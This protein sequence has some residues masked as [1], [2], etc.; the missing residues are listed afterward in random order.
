MRNGLWMTGSGGSGI[1]IARKS[2]GTWSPPSGI[3][4]H[5]PTL[6]FIMGVDVYDCIL[7]VTD[8]VALELL[9]RPQV[10]LGED[11]TLLDGPSVPLS[12]DEV[13][14]SWKDMNG[15]V[16]MYM[17]S[18]GQQQTVNLNGCIL[19]ERAN[20]NERF[21]GSTVSQME[22]LSGSVAR[23]VEETK[24]LFE[25]IKMAE[26]RKDFDQAVI[27]KTAAQPAPGDA[28]IATPTA[29]P[30]SSRA[31]SFGIPK[32]DDPDPFGLLALEMAGMEIRE[33]GAAV[34]P[35]SSQ[36]DFG[37]GALSPS[38]SR[39]P[40]QSID[41][42]LSRSNRASHMSSRTVKSQ[43]TDVAT[44]TETVNSPLA[45]PT[46]RRSGDDLR[47]NDSADSINEAPEIDY[48]TVDTSA[49]RH[50]SQEYGLAPPPAII[51]EEEEQISTMPEAGDEVESN[52]QVATDTVDLSKMITDHIDDINDNANNDNDETVDGDILP[53]QEDELIK[54]DETKDT[55]EDVEEEEEEDFEEDDDEEEPVVFEVAAIQP[56]RTQAVA[57]RVIH[58]RGNVV[59][60]A[61]RGPPPPV[62]RRS[63][64]RSSGAF[65]GDVPAELKLLSSPLREAFSEADLRAEVEVDDKSST[66]PAELAKQTTHLVKSGSLPDGLDKIEPAFTQSPSPTKA[67]TK[68][69][70]VAE[71][72]A[73]I[74]ADAA[75]EMAKRETVATPTPSVTE[76]ETAQSRDSVTTTTDSVL[77]TP[78]S[79]AHTT[80]LVSTEKV[81]SEDE[82]AEVETA[83]AEPASVVP[84][85]PLAVSES[86]ENLNALT[87][88]IPARSAARLSVG[89]KPHSD[90]AHV[91]KQQLDEKASTVSSSDAEP[92]SDEDEL[93]KALRET[94]DPFDVE[95]DHSSAN[96]SSDED[97]DEDTAE[98]ALS[99]ANTDDADEAKEDDESQP[100]TPQNESAEMSDTASHTKH[101]SSIFTGAREDGWSYNGSSMTTPTSDRPASVASDVVDEGTP[102]KALLLERHSTHSSLERTK[103]AS[104]SGESTPTALGIA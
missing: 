17:K 16:M 85:E 23:H 80:A 28:V 64:A 93:V 60:I 75:K 74:E 8:L 19:A 88:A 18:R 51:E 10:T 101:T 59:T 15:K 99:I 66:S 42:S 37:F 5:T 20:E 48:T 103:T 104:D 31:V 49:L 62:P 55:Q 45:S 77:S 43:A 87:I 61:K 76:S 52:P 13:R 22:I 78:E 25:V 56:T 82:T 91:D 21:Y 44:Q 68:R 1:L 84:Q 38:Q 3:M 4:L 95:G 69:S 47:S 100:S 79:P 73:K 24:P 70:A 58:A 86:S 98:P 81:Q 34:R 40:R 32:V 54:E 72:I 63:P 12:V 36:F 27:D 35:A 96:G 53:S 2:D 14:A 46:S 11:I 71:R 89:K 30:I 92:V 26:G 97:R 94:S 41:T 65:T 50:L 83:E 90:D 6:S 39:F 9:T 102:K 33:A 67:P 29:T 7:V 57:S